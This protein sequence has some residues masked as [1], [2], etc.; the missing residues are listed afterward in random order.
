MS[1]ITPAPSWCMAKIQP[2]TTGACVTLGDAETLMSDGERFV[3]RAKEAQ[4]DTALEYGRGQQHIYQIMAG[5]SA[6]A[7]ASIASAGAWLCSRLGL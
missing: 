4:V 1:A 7:D 5:K 2:N 6:E 3:K